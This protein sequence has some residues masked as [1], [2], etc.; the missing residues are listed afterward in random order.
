MR[1]SRPK[2]P[3]ATTSPCWGYRPRGTG[4]GPDTP[5]QSALV[6]PEWWWDISMT[7]RCLQSAFLNPGP[8]SP[9]TQ[10]AWSVDGAR[11]SVS[12][13]FIFHLTLYFMF[14][15]MT[16]SM[17]SASEQL[18][19]LCC[20][21]PNAQQPTHPPRRWESADLLFYWTEAHSLFADH[22]PRDA[23]CRIQ[24]GRGGCV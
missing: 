24:G 23:V 14:Q 8:P 11:Q 12:V 10:S 20:L 19:S 4:A 5:G 9:R 22:N 3:T 13:F 17:V 15:P 7:G 18:G 2:A 1:I 6:N 16:G 21:T